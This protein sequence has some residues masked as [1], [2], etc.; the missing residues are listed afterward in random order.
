VRAGSPDLVGPGSEEMLQRLTADLAFLG[1]DGIDPAR[2][3]FA[4]DVEAA[5]V[6]EGMAAAAAR[7]MV[8]AD[9]SKLGRA[10]GV[11]CVKLTDIDELITDRQADQR[12]VAAIRRAGVKVR[13]V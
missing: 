5:R 8:V 1:S 13:L 7:V 3:S 4:R 12:L 6:A 10:G 9:R 11:R 2:G